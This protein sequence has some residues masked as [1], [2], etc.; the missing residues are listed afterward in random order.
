MNNKESAELKVWD[1]LLI[2]FVLLEIMLKSWIIN[3]T[4]IFKFKKTKVK[5]DNMII[6]LF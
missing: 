4:K 2:N 6:N 5:M 3:S 1:N